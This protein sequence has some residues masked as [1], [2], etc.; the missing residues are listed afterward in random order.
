MQNPSHEDINRIYQG[1]NEAFLET[2]EQYKFPIIR[3]FCDTD[4]GVHLD[5]DEN[6][7]IGYWELYRP[8]DNMLI[9]L[10]DG[11]YH[12]NYS[13]PILCKQD[14]LTIRFVL[15]G[16]LRFDFHNVG[17][18]KIPQ[19]C[20][21][22]LFAKQD[23]EFNL[24]IGSDTHLC[25][26]TIHITPELLIQNFKIDRGKIP[27]L[28][29]DVVFG[30]KLNKHLYN[31]PLSS[32]LIN[33]VMD[34]L[35]MPYS[36][37]RRRLFTEAKVAEMICRLFQ[38]IEEDYEATPILPAPKI[39]LKNKIYRAQALLIE[40]YKSPPT[41]EVLSKEVGLNRSTLCKEFRCIFGTSIFKFCQEYRMNK[42][43][44]YL[45]DRNLS[46]SLVS[47]KLGYDY[48][49]NFTSAFKRHFGYLPKDLR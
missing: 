34:L 48:P 7:G 41:I 1:F 9:C 20:A 25:S 32:G 12:S 26:V 42:A 49:T 19:A 13:Q 3:N 29:D 16:N 39:T 4:D 10:V 40:N 15:S 2:P 28:L 6:H 44:E 17:E 23:A 21:S 35:N 36:G 18:I 30:R 43:R 8:A 31:F 33:I 24:M 37:A 47:E 27:P 45:K 11:L 22:F 46:I 5:L 14:D 38:E